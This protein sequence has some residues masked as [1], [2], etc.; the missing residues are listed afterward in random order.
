MTA[1]TGRL[2]RQSAT[3]AGISSG[4]ALSAAVWLMLASSFFVIKDLTLYNLGGF[5]SY[6]SLSRELGPTGE[7]QAGMFVLTS[8]Y[9]A[10]AAV[11][12][13][14][15]I[16][17]DPLRRWPVFANGYVVGAV[18]ASV[19]GILS[20]FN[21]AGLGFLSPLQRATGTFKDPN[22]LST[23]LLL[24]GLILIQG[25][26]LG[27][28]GHKLL[29]LLS[30]VVILAAIFL[31]FS[32][33]AWISFLAAALLMIVLTFTLTP[34]AP[35]RSRIVLLSILGVLAIAAMVAF[36]LSFD[37]VRSLFLDRLTLEKN[38][39]A[40]ETGRFGNQVNSI[41]YLLQLPL[42]F[43]PTMFGKIMGADPHNTFLNAFSS[44]GWLGGISYLALI[45]STIYIGLKTV[46][47]RTPWQN[48]SIVVFCPLLTTILQ[49]VQID[50]DHWRHFYWMLGLMW[51]LAAAS[52][53]YAA[54]ADSRRK[55]GG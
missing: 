33:G 43:G 22:V 26:M 10:V 24:P 49:G 51:G 16:A 23:Y 41:P 31:A 46:F 17:E 11:F 30:L 25:F 32:R 45:L 36:L 21:I 5:L 27:T 55:F 39:D 20:Y 50:T 19:I 4:M 18:I 8:T 14:L 47:I 9:M 35:L 34:S 6:L 54:T 44:Y 13:A 1:D 28:R 37:T 40:G 53:G 29:R 12:C 52:H 42:G 48:I 7:D 3:L 15:L 38:Y 2:S